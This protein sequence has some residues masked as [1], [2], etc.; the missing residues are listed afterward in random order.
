MM[1][2]TDRILFSFEQVSFIPRGTKN[3]EKIRS[4]LVA[5]A[6]AHGLRSQVDAVGNLVIYVSASVG[7]QNSPTIILQGHLDMVCQKTPDSTHDFT[8]DPIR[9]IRDGDW[10]RADQ[11]TLGADNG[12]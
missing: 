7:M 4:W 1:N 12:I 3:E 11:T 10:I 2:P 8:R 5:W 9:L 6:Q